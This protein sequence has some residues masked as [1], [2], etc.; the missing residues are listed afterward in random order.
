MKKI[1]RAKGHAAQSLLNVAAKGSGLRL[2]GGVPFRDG[3]SCGCG[4]A[5]TCGAELGQGEVAGQGVPSEA[6]G[7]LTFPW[8]NGYGAQQTL[9]AI[10]LD[11]AG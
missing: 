7:T 4:G 10:H 9:K 11:A 3:G 1:E 8:A 2:R 5:F 6:D